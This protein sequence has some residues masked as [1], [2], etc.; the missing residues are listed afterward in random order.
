MPFLAQVRHA[1]VVGGLNPPTTEARFQGTSPGALL[2][3]I[4]RRKLPTYKQTP[5]LT[6]VDAIQTY[7]CLMMCVQDVRWCCF[8]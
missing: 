8:H 6:H 3:T 5:E 2:S 4:D 1:S 7:I